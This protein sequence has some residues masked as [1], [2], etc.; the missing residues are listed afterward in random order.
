MFGKTALSLVIACA[1]LASVFPAP[2]VAQLPTYHLVADL[3]DWATYEVV[4]FETTEEANFTKGDK[5]KFVLVDTRIVLQKDSEGNPRFYQQIGYYDIFVNGEKKWENDTFLI[6]I[7]WPVEEEGYWDDLKALAEDEEAHPPPGVEKYT[8]D[9]EIG[10]W[11]VKVYIH[12]KMSGLFEIIIDLE[13]DKDKGV[14]FIGTLDWKL[15]VPG[16]E[17]RTYFKM[18]LRET[19]LPDVG[20]PSGPPFWPPFI[21]SPEE[22]G[23]APDWLKDFVANYWW[24][25]LLIGSV[26]VIILIIVG[27]VKLIMRRR[28]PAYPYGYPYPPPRYPPPPPSS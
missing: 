23:W 5:L 27:I 2:L 25:Y 7:F 16:A 21:P 8:Y 20:P 1:I 22:W 17:N 18:E 13:V 24:P 15:L 11:D 26:V 14:T 19:S 12:I 28:R 3:G 10:T 4:E 9:V 6:P